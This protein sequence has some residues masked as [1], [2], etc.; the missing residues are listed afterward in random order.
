MECPWLP[1]IPTMTRV[2]VGIVV[3]VGSG[4]EG[5][6]EGELGLGLW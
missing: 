5:L 1:V 3:V 6:I 4:L 2:L